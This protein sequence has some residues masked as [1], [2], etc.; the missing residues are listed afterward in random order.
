LSQVADARYAIE[1]SR[2]MVIMP[3]THSKHLRINAGRIDDFRTFMTGELFEILAT[4][5]ILR[6]SVSHDPD[7]DLLSTDELNS[8]FRGGVELAADLPLSAA[9]FRVRTRQLLNSQADTANRAFLSGILVGS[10][11]VYLKRPDISSY[12]LILCAAPPL[13]N[14]YITAL[15][16]LGIGGRATVVSGSDFQRLTALGQAVVLAKIAAG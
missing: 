13:A 3:G 14:C 9:L 11:L 2:A 12:P 16:A 10:E 1:R 4:H 5:S 15:E 8:A 6:H 7:S